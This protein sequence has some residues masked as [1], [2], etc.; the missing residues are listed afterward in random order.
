MALS[1]VDNM[2]LL[3]YIFDSIQMFDGS[4]TEESSLGRVCG[5]VIPVNIKTVSNLLFLEFY[6][7]DS[8]TYG[9]FKVSYQHIEGK[10]HG[11]Y[12]QV[13]FYS[14]DSIT[15]GGFKVSFQHTEGKLHGYHLHVEYILT[16]LLL[17]EASIFFKHIKSKLYGNHMDVEFIPTTL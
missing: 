1:V 14:D 10:L 15:Y 2:W 9:G 17:T 16:N 13:E 6:S 8:I 11:Y 12:L 3:K 4:F 5:D 7:D